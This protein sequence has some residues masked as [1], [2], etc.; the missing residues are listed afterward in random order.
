MNFIKKQV[1]ELL[2]SSS[3]SENDKVSLKSLNT[4][5][6]Q[7]IASSVILQDPVILENVSVAESASFSLA[8]SE[9]ISVPEKVEIY[10]KISAKC[11]ADLEDCRDCDSV[12]IASKISKKSSK[13][14]DSSS[15]SS[16]SETEEK[17]TKPIVTSGVET[18]QYKVLLDM[19]DLGGR[20]AKFR[21]N[22]VVS[23]RFCSFSEF[24]VVFKVISGQIKLF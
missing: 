16:D 12:S 2:D 13:K 9:S 8:R 14:S 10:E 7:K 11:E 20:N 1:S 4:V 23:D 15:S 22:M 21:L 17:I 19:F 5:D 3:D 18:V 24:L 6:S